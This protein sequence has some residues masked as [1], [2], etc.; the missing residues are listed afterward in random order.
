MAIDLNKLWDCLGWLCW[1]RC[2]FR[3]NRLQCLGAEFDGVR[4]VVRAPASTVRRRVFNEHHGN[5]SQSGEAGTHWHYKHVTRCDYMVPELRQPEQP[6]TVGTTGRLEMPSLPTWPRSLD[7]S[8][9][10]AKL[11][12]SGSLCLTGVS[13]WLLAMA[14]VLG[15]TWPESPETWM[16]WT[17]RWQSCTPMLECPNRGPASLIPSAY[18]GHHR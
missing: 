7:V 8:V 11:A 5:G 6:S 1:C 18:L 15:L 12:T 14:V 13:S 16:K 10:L 4:A 9:G 2:T 17:G 3:A